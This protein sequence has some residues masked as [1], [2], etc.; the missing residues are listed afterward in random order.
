MILKVK[1]LSKHFGGLKAVDKC[2]FS[3]EKGKITALIGPNGA[4]KTTAFNLITGLLKVDEGNI[5]FDKN[6][7]TKLNVD[8]V[9]RAGISRMFQKS[10]MFDNLTVL[11]NLLIAI[12]QEDTYF[13]KNLSG[14]NKDTKEDI[15]LAKE[16]LKKVKMDSFA[17]KRSADLSFG[18]KRLVEIC[19]TILVPH[20]MLM[21]DEPVGGVTPELRK[22]ISELLKDLRKQGETILVIEHDMTFVM[23]IADEIIVMDEGR[24]I[25]KGT[26]SEI[27]KNKLVLEAYL[28]D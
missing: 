12:N 8:E 16:Y 26:P 2:S 19:R 24:V 9:G 15:K 17:N 5:I 3:V 21:L 22:T 27:K 14:K 18:Q 10:R 23:E 20:K 28:G 1:N 13:W 4:G 6:D 25:A 11:E 7:I